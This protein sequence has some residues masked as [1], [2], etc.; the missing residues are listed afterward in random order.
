MGHLPP[1]GIPCARVYSQRLPGV[2]SGANDYGYALSANYNNGPWTV[3]GF[4]Q[5]ARS[6]GDTVNRGN[7]AL[8]AYQF[9]GSYRFSTQI[10]VYGAL[11]FY[12][13]EDEGG[14][15]PTGA[16]DGYVFLLGMRLAL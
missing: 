7:D 12:D 11:Y 5:A 3:G 6:E 8:Q 1:I 14:Q 4:Y 10:R 13:F 16:H 9:G 15:A 2:V